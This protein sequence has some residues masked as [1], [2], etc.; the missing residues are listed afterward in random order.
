MT[1]Q[2]HVIFMASRQRG[3]VHSAFNA[4]FAKTVLDAFPEAEVQFTVER[5]HAEYLNDLRRMFP[6]PEWHRLKLQ[7]WKPDGTTWITK[8]AEGLKWTL[9]VLRAAERATAQVLFVA[10]TGN[11]LLECLKCAIQALNVRFPVIVVAHTS[12][13]ALTWNAPALNRTL[14]TTAI[15]P[16]QP[17]VLHYLTLSPHVE[18]A[19]GRIC[20]QMV[21]HV[22][23]ID[24]PIL[25]AENEA[26]EIERRPLRFGFFG[27]S[28]KGLEEFAAIARDVKK[29]FPTVEFVFGGACTEKQVATY[30]D[31]L[32][33]VSKRPLS[34]AAYRR[35]LKS[36]TYGVWF[37][38]ANHYRMRASGTL[39]ELFACL[40][41][42]LCV[43]NDLTD[44]YFSRAKN[45][46]FQCATLKELALK[47]SDIAADFPGVEY[48]AQIN[49]LKRIRA[50]FSPDVVAKQ[51]RDIV[52]R[53]Q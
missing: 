14:N 30:S 31:V 20:P 48:S 47:I 51:L 27:I 53:L 44:E 34:T 13:E 3:F 40:K 15:W 18:Q 16:P 21:P 1:R 11:A 12:F 46:G 37:S 36:V 8:V 5:G 22:S 6:D 26:W 45:I 4:A 35:L 42:V 7:E 49:D 9:M 39:P 32:L 19:I 24:H 10:D 29:K 41:P 43:K 25:G 17:R 28:S 23:A 38:T 33:A 2:K 50:M 52:I